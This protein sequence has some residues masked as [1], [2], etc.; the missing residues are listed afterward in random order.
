MRAKAYGWLGWIVALACVAG[1]P[2][3]GG[4]ARGEGPLPEYEP[5]SPVELDHEQ[6]ELVEE[7]ETALARPEADCGAAC[8]L[9]DRICELGERICAIAER[10]PEDTETAGRCRD[11][12]ERCD[13][14]RERLGGSCSCAP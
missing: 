5:E 13:R 12:S 11:G 4:A 9:G 8:D 10:H 6:S 2:A 3:C 1:L 14:A 7:L